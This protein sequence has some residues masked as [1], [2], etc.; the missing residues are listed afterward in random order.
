MELTEDL[1]I[2]RQAA[3]QLAL[4]ARLAAR[5]AARAGSEPAAAEAVLAW[6]I[7][8]ASGGAGIALPVNSV[9][10]MV[11]VVE[12]PDLVP[13]YRLAADQAEQLLSHFDSEELFELAE[14]YGRVISVI[15][16]EIERMTSP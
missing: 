6:A 14:L 15:E 3:A 7:L 1:V 12:R 10:S 2:P 13:A 16:G 11:D 9:A 4:H 8:L 5:H